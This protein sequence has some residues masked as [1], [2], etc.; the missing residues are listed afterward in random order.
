MNN[1]VLVAIIA[2][3]SAIVL[4]NV[5]SYIT[6]GK[7]SAAKGN[8]ASMQ[9]AAATYYDTNSNYT[10]WLTSSDYVKISAAL[11]AANSLRFSA[12]RLKRFV[13]MGPPRL[14]RVAI[15]LR[16]PDILARSIQC[17]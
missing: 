13:S 2:V 7:D 16:L 14:R 17:C 11:T 3:L 1:K 10:G 9:V 8:L 4:V 5:T 6:K 12:S 15:W